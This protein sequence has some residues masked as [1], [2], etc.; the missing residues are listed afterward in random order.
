MR[1]TGYSPIGKALLTDTGTMSLSDDIGLVLGKRGCAGRWEGG[2]YVPCGSDIAPF[3][4]RCGGVLPDP[5]ITCRGECTKPERTC[6]MEHSVY[7]AVFSPGLVKVGVSRAMRL[8]TRLMEQGADA[9][10][11]VARFP[12]GEAA[13]RRERELAAAYADRVTFDNKVEGLARPVRG[14]VLRAVCRGHEAGR[15][16]RFE[17]FREHLRMRPIVIEP[18]RG[19]AIA[20]RVMGVKGQALV[21]E[22]GRT[23]YA[24]NLDGL[25]GYDVEPG[26]GNARLQASLL[27]FTK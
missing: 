3:C 11:E 1:I 8:E 21:V 17:Y 2:R 5:C 18:R 27:E 16:M 26:K 15:L 24:V 13:R 10:L 25:V 12:D 20:G 22:R 7:L 14:D 19:L 9:G 6:T 4:E 23:L